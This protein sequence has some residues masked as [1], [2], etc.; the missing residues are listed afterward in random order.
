MNLALLNEHYV[1]WPVVLR[2]MK[3]CPVK[4]HKMDYNEGYNYRSIHENIIEC[5]RQ[6]IITEYFL[7]IYSNVKFYCNL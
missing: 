6:I 4:I 2:R 5:E 3:E 7:P 1:I